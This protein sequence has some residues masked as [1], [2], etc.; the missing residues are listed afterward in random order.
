MTN[1]SFGGKYHIFVGDYQD[2]IV[3]PGQPVPATPGCTATINGL[4]TT[5]SLSRPPSAP[6]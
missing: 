4:Q 5:D 6:P 1:S 2:L 3:S